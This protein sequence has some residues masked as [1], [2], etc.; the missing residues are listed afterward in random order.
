MKQIEPVILNRHSIRL[1]G[2]DYTQSGLYFITTCVQ[3]REHMFGKIVE[4]EM[5][6]NDAGETVKMVWDELPQHYFNIQLDAFVIM[7]DHIHGIIIITEP[8]SIHAESC[9]HGLSEIVRGLKTFSAR[10]INEL[11]NTPGKKLWQRNYYEHIIRDEREYLNIAQYIENN[12]QKWEKDHS[13][14]GFETRPDEILSAPQKISP[15][16]KDKTP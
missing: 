14:G 2:Y 1:K 10:K 6:L 9:S 15:P 13:T 3:N 4:G 5:I 12:P 7:P 8:K 16:I 11:H